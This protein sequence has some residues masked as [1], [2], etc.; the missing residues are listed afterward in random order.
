MSSEPRWSPS[1]RKC[2]ASLWIEVGMSWAKAS[3]AAATGSDALSSSVRRIQGPN[4][5]GGGMSGRPGGGEKDS[6]GEGGGGD[7]SKG[8]A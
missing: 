3:C 7:G 2:V 1:G 8:R 5:N 4:S 6:E